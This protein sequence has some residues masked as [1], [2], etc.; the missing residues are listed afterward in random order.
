MGFSV[1][2]FLGVIAGFIVG[3]RIT[4]RQYAE[5][6]K[7]AKEA[8]KDDRNIRSAPHS[9]L[10]CGTCNV[11]RCSYSTETPNAVACQR[12]PDDENGEVKKMNWLLRLF[13]PDNQ[14]SLPPEPLLTKRPK[15][16]TLDCFNPRCDGG[17]VMVRGRAIEEFWVR[18]QKCRRC[19]GIKKTRKEA[20]EEWAETTKRWRKK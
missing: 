4:N 9:Q 15:K 6:V 18:C 5:I 20:I 11:G 19:T 17:A 8:D 12:H 2:V 14:A 3:C 10:K 13:V 16:E 7:K 1:G